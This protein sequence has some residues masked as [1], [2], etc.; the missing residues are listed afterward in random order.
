MKAILV[1]ERQLGRQKRRSNDRN[2]CSRCI[3]NETIVHTR[4]HFSLTTTRCY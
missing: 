3:A 1:A 2:D 4:L